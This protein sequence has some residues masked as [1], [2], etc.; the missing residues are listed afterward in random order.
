MQP[1]E[2]VRIKRASIGAP[3]GSIGLIVEVLVSSDAGIYAIQMVGGGG[4][5]ARKVKRLG[6]DLEVISGNR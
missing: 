6:T 3:E 1:G 2:L 4:T 5:R